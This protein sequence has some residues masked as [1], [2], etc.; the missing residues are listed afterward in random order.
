MLRKIKVHN[1]LHFADF[2]MELPNFACMIGNDDASLADVFRLIDF[3]GDVSGGISLRYKEL[4]DGT[5]IFGED[6]YDADS[7]GIFEL[8]FEF[9]KKKLVWK[10][11]FDYDLKSCSEERLTIDGE[12]EIILENGMLSVKDKPSIPVGNISFCNIYPG[13]CGS[14]LKIASNE[15][16][17]YAQK[18]LDYFMGR[19][20][21][22]PR[23]IRNALMEIARMCKK[24]EGETYM[25]NEFLRTVQY[26]NKNIVEIELN[27]KKDNF[28]F[29]MKDK[30][31][32]PAE[33]AGNL[34]KM[35]TQLA[36][37]KK[38]NVSVLYSRVLCDFA[39]PDNIAK[40]MKFME[41]HLQSC[42]L[43]LTTNNPVFVNYIPEDKAKDAII[44][45]YAN[46]D[47]GLIRSVPFLKLKETS[48]KYG[49]LGAGEI[50]ADTNLYK[51]DKTELSE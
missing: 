37:F 15:G 23:G 29:V 19:K 39:S 10:G 34:I 41:E 2:T 3:L 6:L 26:F 40:L 9:D 4:A 25:K 7:P 36:V 22:E 46:K 33:S 49:V 20:Y 44:L 21:V 16:S 5:E 8:E 1:M 14:Y 38:T 47:S 30:R 45:I 12:D 17:V 43:I 11:I 24:T 28:S 13:S 32:I 51:L 18:I 48:A 27:E 50:F 35:I 42:Q 31:K